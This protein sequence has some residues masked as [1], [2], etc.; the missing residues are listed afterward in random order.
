MRPLVSDG[1]VPATTFDPDFINPWG[2]VFAPNAPVWVVNNATST[3]RRYNGAGVEQPQRVSLPGGINGAAAPTGAVF[4]ATGDFVVSNGMSSAAASFIIDGEGG[5]LIGWAAAISQNTGLIAYDDGSGGAVYKGLAFAMSQGANLLYAT[6]FRN[7]KI[8]VFDGNFQKIAA[9]GGFADPSLPA[10]Y[11]PFGIRAITLGGETVLFV[12][13]AQR[14]GVSNDNVNGAGLGLVNLFDT[15]GTLRSRFVDTGGRLNA[16]WGIALAPAGFG[17]LGDRVLI[18]NFGDGVINAYDAQTGAFVDSV[19]DA[20]GQPIA[21]PGLW[22]LAFGN[23]AQDQPLDTLFFTAGLGSGAGGLYGRIDPVAG[24]GDGAVPPPPPGDGSR[25]PPGFGSSPGDPR[26]DSIPPTVQVEVP[27]P[28]SIVTDIITILAN[29]TD[30]VGVTSVEFFVGPFLIGVATQPPFFVDWD[31]T[32]V[33]NGDL[34]I[35]ARARDAAGN[36]G[37]SV[38]VNIVVSNVPRPR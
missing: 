29:A 15:S 38:P 11:A 31:S 13:Y 24:T 4:N 3:V 28:D 36:I 25:D 18:G 6:D 7:N 20:S 16:P 26:A 1:S 9:P 5:T 37:G 32:T 30:N 10:G 2:I 17:P 33:G 8:D 27:G 35:V 14:A 21:T 19:K 34:Q 23:G 22:G 12:T